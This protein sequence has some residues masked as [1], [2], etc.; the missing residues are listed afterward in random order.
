MTQ[1]FTI[2][3][4]LLAAASRAVQA[5]EPQEIVNRALALVAGTGPLPDVEIYTDERL[6]EFAESE[7]ELGGVLRRKG[8]L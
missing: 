8:L 1:T 4:A 7:A 2:D 6:A 3:D 5:S